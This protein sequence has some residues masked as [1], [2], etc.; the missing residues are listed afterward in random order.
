MKSKRV[1]FPFL[2]LLAIAFASG[3]PTVAFAQL[4][5]PM[6]PTAAVTASPESVLTGEEIT[7][8]G[9]GSTAVLGSIEKYEWDLE[10]DGSYDIDTTEAVITHAYSAPGTYTVRLRV[11]DGQSQAAEA[12]VNVRVMAR[13][14]AGFDVSPASPVSNTPVGFTS[15]S[16]DPDGTIESFE[17][18]FDGDGDFDDD[19]S[20]SPT[21]TFSTP[22]VKIVTLRVTDN[23]G[24]TAVAT[25]TFVV[26]NQSPTASFTFLPDPPSTGETVTFTSTSTDPDGSSPSLAWDLDNDGS[27]DD[28]SDQIVTRTFST[29]GP[30]TISLR[31]TDDSGASSI[32]T[33]VVEVRNR[34]PTGV[35][36]TYSPQEFQTFEDV[37]FTASASD[38]EGQALT[39]QWDFDGNGV[40]EKSG[41]EVVHQFTS[42]GANSVTLRV[43]DANDESVTTLPQTVVPDNRAPTAA[44]GFQPS[45]PK[46]GED[47]TFTSTSSDRDGTIAEHRWYFDGD[48]TPDA[49]G[50][51]VVRQFALPGT[52]AVRL[53]VVDDKG[54]SHVVT[55]DVPVE[56]RPPTASFE[57]SSATPPTLEAVSF[58]ASATDPEGQPLAYQ[59]DLDNDGAYPDAVGPTAQRTYPKSGAQTVKLYVVDSQNAVAEATRTFVV[60]NRAPTASFTHSPASPRAFENVRFTSTSGDLDG[61]VASQAWD[62]DNDGSF[63]D[64][65]LKTATK[66]FTESKSYTVRLRVVDDEG[67]EAIGVRTLVVGNRPPSASF[68]YLPSQPSADELVSF[69]STA[70]DADSPIASQWWDLDGDGGY[71]DASGETASRSYPAGNHNVGLVVTDSE[72][73]SAFF[74]QTIQVT[75]PAPV[76][77]AR[78]TGSR[79]L[80]PFPVVRIAGAVKRRGTRLRR[81]TVDAPTG[82]TVTV[83]CRGKGCPFGRQSRVVKSSAAKGK[84]RATGV[85]RI[86]RV[87]RRLLR[88]GT[89]ITIF[90]TKEETIGKYT[91]FKIRKGR[92]PARVDRCLLPGQRRPL[93]CPPL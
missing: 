50:P 89:V 32:A 24:L 25:R 67:T 26:Q 27:F 49:T 93:E 64:G 19:F 10:G 51:V 5:D 22:G 54:S 33:A 84:Q 81:L 38:P 74:V 36:F 2:S 76:H 16:T 57:I 62:L 47:V 46:T 52:H 12:T 79:L 9:S 55:K 58:T 66:R 18:E 83:R 86:R 37:T 80:S 70:S 53:E 17:W 23:D 13:P 85:L 45:A 31:A 20:S 28:A 40:F 65:T 42:P 15:T 39:Y 69:F 68:G 63:D 82:S 56:N 14:R 29:P 61:S 11:T 71:D 48:S 59:W 92:P 8:D 21:R 90:V 88:A 6:A 35:G 3:A 78:A 34:P 73:E 77:Q 91:R 60:Q 7:F 41:R 44:F 75:T 4:P 1:L 30:K 87:E 43:T 72:G